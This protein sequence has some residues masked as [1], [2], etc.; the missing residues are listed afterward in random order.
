MCT[1]LFAGNRFTRA[2][3]LKKL[4]DIRNALVVN[5]KEPQAGVWKLNVQSEGKHTIRVTGLSTTDFIAGFSRKPVTNLKETTHR[6]VG[7]TSVLFVIYV[8]LR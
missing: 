6:P 4:L 2:D 8:P 7:G 3:G 5:V 1:V